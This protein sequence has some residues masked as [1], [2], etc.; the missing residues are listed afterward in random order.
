MSHDISPKPAGRM[1]GRPFAKGRS[2]PATGFPKQSTLAAAALLA[3]E[4][5]P[6]DVDRRARSVF[7]QH[8]RCCCRF[9][10]G[11]AIGNNRCNS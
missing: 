3:R 9:A 2:G 5:D 4:S 1:H 6:A 11:A 8:G 10:A 7:N